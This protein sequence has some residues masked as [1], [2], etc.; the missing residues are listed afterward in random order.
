M[1]RATFGS[2]ALGMIEA[3]SVGCTVEMYLES[4]RIMIF[5]SWLLAKP[6]VTK[7]WVRNRGGAGARWQ[8]HVNRE[9]VAPHLSVDPRRLKPGI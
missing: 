2:S 8:S 7:G 4:A 9:F 5:E 6:R 1:T 3:A